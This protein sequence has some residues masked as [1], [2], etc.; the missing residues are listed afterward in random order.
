MEDIV[1]E[2]YEIQEKTFAIYSAWDCDHG[3]WPARGNR[4]FCSGKVS[5]SKDFIN[6]EKCPA[7]IYSEFFCICI[8]NG[9]ETFVRLEQS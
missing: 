5:Y 7:D 2:G 6:Y 1:T 4:K 3:V 9:E 8:N